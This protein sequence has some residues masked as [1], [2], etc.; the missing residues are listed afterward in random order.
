MPDRRYRMFFLYAGILL[1]PMT[2]EGMQAYE[3]FVVNA[4]FWLLLGILFQLPTLAVSAQFA[5]SAQI[6]AMY[7]PQIR[8]R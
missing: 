6:A 7:D 2:F 4:Y 5:A 1:L 3:D 8:M